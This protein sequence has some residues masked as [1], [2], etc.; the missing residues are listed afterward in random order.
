[1]HSSH[2]V[3]VQV[4]IE[5]SHVMPVHV[6]KVLKD[7]INLFIEFIVTKLVIWHKSI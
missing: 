1:M 4:D 7:E 2:C 3:C 5:S 6:L